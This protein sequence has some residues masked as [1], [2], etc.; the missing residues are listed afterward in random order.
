[1]NTFISIL[2]GVPGYWFSKVQLLRKE[3]VACYLGIDRK[4]ECVFIPRGN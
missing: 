3:E 1:M 2:P 4:L